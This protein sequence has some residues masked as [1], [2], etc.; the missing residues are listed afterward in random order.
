MKRLLSCIFLVYFSSSLYSQTEIPLK[1]VAVS[2]NPADSSKDNT[3]L[4]VEVEAEYPGG[5]EG[6]KKFLIKGLA[7]ATKDAIKDKQPSGTYIL[8]VTFIVMKDGYLII[9]DDSCTP[10]NKYLEAKCSEMISQSKNW[11]PATQNGKPVK[12]YRKQPIT[13]VID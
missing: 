9:H 10:V 2:A 11:K 13:I 5:D 8:L 12:A 7:K 1:Q 3:F 4:K 6:W